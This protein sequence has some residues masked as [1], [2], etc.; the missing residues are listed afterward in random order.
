MSVHPEIVRAA[1]RQAESRAADIDR[2]LRA[3]GVKAVNRSK[4]DSSR[5]VA[6]TLGNGDIIDC[7]LAQLVASGCEIPRSSPEAADTDGA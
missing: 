4:V 7:S 3:H 6:V 2:R 5:N 1:R